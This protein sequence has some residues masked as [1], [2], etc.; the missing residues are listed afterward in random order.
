MIYIHI[1]RGENMELILQNSSLNLLSQVYQAF[2]Q[3][4]QKAYSLDIKQFED[5]IEKSFIEA[6]PEDISHYWKTI[7]ETLKPASVNRKLNSL[8]ALYKR[9]QILGLTKENPVESAKTLNAVR[10][11]VKAQR[12]LDLLQIED[13]KKAL[14]KSGD[15]RLS[16][17]IKTLATTGLRITE[18]INVKMVDIKADERDVSV[19]IHGKGGRDRIVLLPFKLYNALLQAFKPSQDGYLFT[20]AGRKPYIRQNLYNQIRKLFSSSEINGVHPH[21]FR[22][23]YATTKI[24][25][26]GDVKAVSTYLGH[27]SARTTLDFYCQS[28]L[29]KI[30]AFI[31]I[32]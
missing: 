25:E 12:N 32:D 3:N 16:L 27:A 17:I 19:L 14:S 22:H 11:M 31:N 30:N 20:T 23:F 21:A 6:C 15:S 1:Y 24:K 5:F 9:S 18:L 13:I 29:S 8:S 7:K 26:T 2:S 28:K 10:P 4:T